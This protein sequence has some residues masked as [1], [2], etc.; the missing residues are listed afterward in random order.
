MEEESPVSLQGAPFEEA[1]KL[2]R[3]SAMTASLVSNSSFQ[4]NLLLEDLVEDDSRDRLVGGR[5]I[6]GSYGYKDPSEKK[7]IIST[8]LEVVMRRRRRSIFWGY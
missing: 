6:V 5:A 2:N 3:G 1:Y 4:L 8:S 7:R